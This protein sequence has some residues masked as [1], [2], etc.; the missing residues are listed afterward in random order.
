MP[1]ESDLYRQQQYVK[2]LREVTAGD[3]LGPPQDDDN[4]HSIRKF[5]LSGNLFP[6][7]LIDRMIAES[8]LVSNEDRGVIM[9]AAGERFFFRHR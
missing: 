7:E 4:H 8:L 2:V 3:T 5:E 1:D 6:V 9:A